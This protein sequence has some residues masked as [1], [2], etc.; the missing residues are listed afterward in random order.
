MDKERVI[1][2]LNHIFKMRKEFYEFF[3][4]SMPKIANTDVFD[5]KNS[6]PLNAQ[7]VYTLF[8]K[9]DYALRKLLPSVYKA[10]EIDMERDLSKD[11]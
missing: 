11:F 4:N 5:F 6:K 9:Y 8:N 10:Y 3:D 2:N 7:E 1:E